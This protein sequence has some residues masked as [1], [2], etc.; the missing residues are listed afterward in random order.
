MNFGRLYG[1]GRAGLVASAR[2]QYGL[3]L[4]LATAKAW[5][6]AFEAAY[7]DF[8]RWC[9]D[10]ARAC[11]RSGRIPIGREGG[12][13]HEIHWNPEGYRYTQCLAWRFD[14]DTLVRAGAI[15][16]GAYVEGSLKLPS[17]DD[18]LAIE[19]ESSAT[20]PRNSW[21]RLRYAIRDYWTGEQHQIDDKIYLT[22]SRP[23]FGGQRWWFVCPNENRRV[24]KLYL[25]PGAR[26]FRSRRAYR[27]AY[28]SQREAVHDRAMRRA[29]KLC[30]RL[31]GD[32]MD[33]H[34]PEKP[35]RMRG[36]RTTDY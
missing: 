17:R 4:D 10:F 15:K 5:I 19:F 11:E 8:T 26:R 9:Q 23:W 18:E 32:P 24:R 28:A 31:G 20:N 33:G 21:L 29:R 2:E 1:Q 25:P 12:R 34:Y 6:G 35:P 7:P 27:L 14:I 16:P 13:V 3:I 36:P 30:R 22:A